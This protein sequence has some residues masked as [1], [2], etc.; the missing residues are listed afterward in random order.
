M[1]MVA[2]EDALLALSR[3][4]VPSMSLPPHDTPP[5]VRPALE[6]VRGAFIGAKRVM[7]TIVV[8]DEASASTAFRSCEI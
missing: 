6:L 8:D 2:Y 7:L 3:R 5:L 1:M 4:R